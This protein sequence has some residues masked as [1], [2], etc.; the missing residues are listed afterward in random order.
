MMEGRNGVDRSFRFVPFRP[1]RCRYVEM[2]L[3][4]L[5]VFA[6]LSP[7]LNALFILFSGDVEGMEEERDIGKE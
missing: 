3:S 6:F 7:P 5:C 4:N 1:S 2:R